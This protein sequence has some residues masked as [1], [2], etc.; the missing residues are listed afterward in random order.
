[1]ASGLREP[2]HAVPREPAPDVPDRAATAS[3]PPDLEISSRSLFAFKA[4]YSGFFTDIRQD[5]LYPSFYDHQQ[6]EASKNSSVALPPPLPSSASGHDSGNPSAAVAALS[7]TSP[8]AVERAEGDLS[9]RGSTHG[10]GK[11]S[12]SALEHRKAHLSSRTA[13]LEPEHGGQIQQTSNFTNASLRP[14]QPLVHSLEKASLHSQH[15]SSLPVQPRLSREDSESSVDDLIFRAASASSVHHN[16]QTSTPSPVLAASS[17]AAAISTS[18]ISQSSSSP[19]MR[20]E[21]H[22]RDLR[23][24][25]LSARQQNTTA[26]EHGGVSGIGSGHQQSHYSLESFPEPAGRRPY[27]QESSQGHLKERAESGGLGQPHFHG[28]SANPEPHELSVLSSSVIQAGGQSELSSHAGLMQR[29]QERIRDVEYDKSFASNHAPGHPSQIHG[30]LLH[31]QQLSFGHAPALEGQRIRHED[32]HAPSHFDPAMGKP[33]ET[34]WSRF[35]HLTIGRDGNTSLTADDRAVV[36]SSSASGFSGAIGP[37]YLSQARQHSDAHVRLME[38]QEQYLALNAFQPGTVHSQSQAHV[39]VQAQL[40]AQAQARARVQAQAY[41]HAYAATAGGVSGNHQNFQSHTQQTPQSSQQILSHPPRSQ[42]RPDFRQDRLHGHG[43][44]LESRQLNRHLVPH[45]FIPPRS[46]ARSI[47]SSAV[48]VQNALNTS[49]HVE[50]GNHSI[51]TPAPM[52]ILSYDAGA[53][54]DL[55]VDYMSAQAAA[56]AAAAAAAVYQNGGSA[57]HGGQMGGAGMMPNGSIGHV[58]SP[59]VPNRTAGAG[60]VIGANGAVGRIGQ[61]YG[62]GRGNRSGGKGLRNASLNPSYDSRSTRNGNSF[63]DIQPV[64]GSGGMHSVGGI[65]S[66]SGNNL[67]PPYGSGGIASGVGGGPTTGDGSHSKLA[68]FNDVIGRAEEL[69]RDQHGCRFLQT[70]LEEGNPSYINAIFEECYEKFVDLMTDPFGNYLCQKLFEYCNDAQRLALVERCAPSIPR[71]STN[72]HGTRAVQRMVECLSTPEQ[73]RAVCNSLTPAAV[74]LMK[75]INGNHVIQRCLHRM[76]LASNQFVYDAVA[77]NC[78][79]LATHRHGCCVMQRCMDHASAAQRDQLAQQINANALPLVQNAFGNYVVQYVLELNEPAYT[80]E[81]IKRL[82]GHVAELSTQKFSS[83]VIEKSLQLGSRETRRELID[84]LISDGET[85]RQL[86]HDAYGNYV[87]QRALQVAES[88][89]L[90]QICDAISPHL[91]ALKQSPYGKRIQAKI[92]KRMPKCL[93]ANGIIGAPS[94]PAQR[95]TVMEPRQQPQA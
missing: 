48:S 95:V 45:P 4:D 66:V 58:M 28:H 43:N 16:L 87:I 94:I 18:T 30:H 13:T 17:V 41:V 52:S 79:E 82:R 59:S 50:Y 57:I 81:I 54:S 60:R 21:E 53:G 84:E 23:F 33:S 78:F 51:R 46:G 76:E 35:D 9:S 65:G 39:Q 90:E 61:S 37:F 56:A 83:N 14:D 3:A 12:A 69:A 6:R 71:V 11:Q 74:S 89:Q 93:P 91:N 26:A 32:V 55:A 1:M 22:Q 15:F 7:P 29:D 70:K 64:H 25:P 19:F 68:S 85:M 73:V 72:M 62:N 88:P 75:D 86:L 49:M 2:A 36:S 27:N 80:S 42:L 20:Q 67:G 8:A 92:L 63:T 44:A 34:I 40:Q 10:D 24:G 77:N 31:Q 38:Q 5:E 47:G